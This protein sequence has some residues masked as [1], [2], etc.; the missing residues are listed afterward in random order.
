[1]GNNPSFSKGPKNPVENRSA[2]NQHCQASPCSTQC[3][4]WRTNRESL[5]SPD[6]RRAMGICLPSREARRNI[7]FGDDESKLDRLSA[8]YYKN[9]GDN[10]TH[11][12]GERK[13]NAWGLYDMHGNV[14]EWCQDWYSGVYYAQSPTDDPPGP[15]AWLNRVLRGGNWSQNA[16][17]V[18]RSASRHPCPPTFHTDWL[19]LP[20]CPSSF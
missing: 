12:V 20:C 18:C 5:F 14:W 8:W 6:G 7:G 1:M 19:G 11:P 15:G 13:P 4:D 2:G 16:K 3:E 9:S 10:T 17:E